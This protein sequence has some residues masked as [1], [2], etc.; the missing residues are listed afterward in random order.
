[1][2]GCTVTIFDCGNKA[3]LAAVVVVNISR[4]SEQ[5]GTVV[6]AQDIVIDDSHSLVVS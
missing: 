5:Q 6:V 4:L 2:N 3:R 1:V